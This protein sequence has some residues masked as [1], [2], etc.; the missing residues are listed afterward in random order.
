MEVSHYFSALPKTILVLLQPLAF[1]ELIKMAKLDNT[2]NSFIT[3]ERNR[4][5]K[6]NEDARS[7][8]AQIERE[9]QGIERELRA[10]DAYEAAKSIDGAKAGI[11]RPARSGRRGEKRE[12]V[13]RI[14]QKNR[15]GVSRGDI[16]RRLSLKGNKSG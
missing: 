6:A 3:K 2:F 15:A 4:L 16:I 5:K 13:L 8:K 1:M 9:L 7:R 12:Q 10:I 11:K 14:I